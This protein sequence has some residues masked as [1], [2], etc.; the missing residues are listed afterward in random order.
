[1]D[2]RTRGAIKKA[3]AAGICAL[4]IGGGSL[5]AVKLRHPA[6][7]QEESAPS[8]AMPAPSIPAIVVAKEPVRLWHSF[9]GRLAAV[10]FVEL[11]P[12]VSG[13]IDAIKFQDGAH[14]EKGDVLFIIDPRPF[15][16]NAQ[17]A[18]AALAAAQSQYDFSQK[19]LRRAEDLIKT[20]AISQSA[21]DKRR[22]DA[23]LAKNALS[24]AKAFVEEA[25]IDLDHAYLKAPISGRVSRAEVTI[26]N[27]VQAGPNAPVLTS[28]VSDTGIYADFEIDEKT[29]LKSIRT[30]PLEE[31][32]AKIIPVQILPGDG[33]VYDGTLKS[34]DNH[35]DSS[36][37]T[38]RARA[39]F[40]NADGALVPGMYVSVKIGSPM[41]EDA[42]LL[43]DKAIGTD[44]DRK[45][46]YIIDDSGMAA[47]REI[48][49]GDT[50][51]GRRII[52]DG[53]APGDKVITD[54]IVKIR[55]GMPVS[56]QF[57]AGE[58]STGAQE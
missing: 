44:Q 28:I 31:E 52:T 22:N 42:I 32:A 46:V 51:D 53:L 23:I 45:F 26:G 58:E 25:R 5:W 33:S 41:T 50:V 56:P 12:Q 6:S 30:K 37:G 4:L 24:G 1:M 21:L 29:Y 55:P 13:R 14:V 8:G 47:Y 20:E 48:T 10:D 7:A 40:D 36:T 27:L 49:P 9:A 43:T 57:A 18:D 15:E 2:K 38:I 34:F 39:Y 11:R 17:K 54:G 3:L 16:A 19:E 35:I